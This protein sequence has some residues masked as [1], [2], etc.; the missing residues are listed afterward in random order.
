MAS[1]TL[2]NVPDDLR[3][4]LKAQAA[5]HG[6]SLNQEILQCLRAALPDGEKLQARLQALNAL[7][8]RQKAEGVW[9]SEDNLDRWKRE[10]RA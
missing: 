1:I 6:R 7:H 2:K 4:K 3:L 8:Q 10:G 5:K 9:L